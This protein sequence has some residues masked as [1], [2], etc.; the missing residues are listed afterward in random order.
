MF[1]GNANLHTLTTTVNK[2][3]TLWIDLEDFSGESRYAEYGE[4]SVGST[5]NFYQLHLT[6]FNG[7]VGELM[8]SWFAPNSLQ[9]LHSKYD[10]GG[11]VY[12]TSI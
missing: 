1:P 11:D 5:S 6:G 3:Y 9:Q 8:I 4:F 7:D 2:V 10:D 12:T